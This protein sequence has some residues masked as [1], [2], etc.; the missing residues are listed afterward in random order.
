MCTAGAAPVRR[1]MAG[2]DAG[3]RGAVAVRPLAR[4]ERIEALLDHA[5]ER[6]MVEVDA[7]IDHRDQHLVAARQRDAPRRGCSLASAYWRRVRR[8]RAAP[9]GR[10]RA[11]CVS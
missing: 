3:D 5:G 11:H 4:V 6:R 1:R 7:G 10:R 9:G 8:C 2:D